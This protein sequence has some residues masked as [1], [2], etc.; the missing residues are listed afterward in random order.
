MLTGMLVLQINARLLRQPDLQYRAP[1][2]TP[3]HGSWNLKNHQFFKPA[4]LPAY[5]IVSFMTPDRVGRHNDPGSLMAS[6]LAPC[7]A[8]VL[9]SQTRC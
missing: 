8:S 2:K 1:Y 5:A 7:C 6:A 4:S 3:P 9:S